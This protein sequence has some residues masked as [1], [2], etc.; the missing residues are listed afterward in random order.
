M[1]AAPP[2]QVGAQEPGSGPG[3]FSSSHQGE[4]SP[5]LRWGMFLT[6][7]R[8]TLEPLIP[9]FG[10]CLVWVLV[11]V[12]PASSYDDEWVSVSSSCCVFSSSAE[13]RMDRWVMTALVHRLPVFRS[14]LVVMVMIVVSSRCPSSSEYPVVAPAAAAP[15]SRGSAT[16]SS[17]QVL[18]REGLRATI[19]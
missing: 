1:T 2:T 14:T 4:G 16:A 8:R 17:D 15:S 9:P 10:E 11:W 3:D 12:C 19:S 7:T 5:N 13:A 18:E 6:V